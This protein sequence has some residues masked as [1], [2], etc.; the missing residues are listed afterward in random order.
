MGTILT[1]SHL[2]T[3]VERCI[4]TDGCDSTEARACRRGMGREREARNTVV[5]NS[6][7][8]TPTS[9]KAI[10]MLTYDQ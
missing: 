7:D 3:I 9:S 2:D 10:K 6:T 8:F 5:R 4:L 1:D